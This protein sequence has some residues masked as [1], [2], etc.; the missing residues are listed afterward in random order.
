MA[1]TSTPD[2]PRADASLCRVLRPRKGWAGIGFAELW[3]YRELLAVFV[4]RDI[5]VRYKQTILGAAWAII[6]PVMTMVVF[7]IFFGHL[8]RMPSD[9]FPYPVFAYAALLPWT[10][11]ATSLSSAANSIAD[12][13]G[14]ITK[15]YFPRLMLP[16]VP[17]ISGLVDF[18]VAFL[19][20]IGLMAWFGI[21]PTIA[22]LWLPALLLLA[23][24]T[25]LAAGM[26]LA[27]LNALYRDFRY[28]LGFI[29]QFW[30]FATPVAYPT[31]LVPEKYRL[32]YG[33][34]PMVGVVE[35]F[36]WALLGGQNAPGPMLLVSA[37][38]VLVFL[39]GGIEFFR[40]LERTFVDRV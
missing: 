12:N 5:K 6:Q 37:G 13:R 31:S 20:L 39:I 27:G 26:W 9:G 14:M 15:V 40:R 8:A 3:R 30:L 19:V 36:R 28:T 38:V 1:E 11:F 24:A 16:M 33:L 10:Y 21:V 18:G 34:N 29:I 35:G 22:V 32:L 7:S 4:W 17:M 23:M 2:S 25:S